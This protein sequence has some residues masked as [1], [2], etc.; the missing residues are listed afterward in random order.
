MTVMLEREDAAS[1]SRA[2][3]ELIELRALATEPLAGLGPQRFVKHCAAV[4]IPDHRRWEGGECWGTGREGWGTGH[5][6]W[7]Q[8]SASVGGR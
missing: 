2:L 7:R 1:R 5:E 8:R 4:P 3:I 6:C